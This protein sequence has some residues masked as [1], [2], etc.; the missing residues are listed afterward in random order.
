MKFALFG[1]NTENL[2]IDNLNLLIRRLL[3][4]ENVEL[5][6]YKPF[7]ESIKEKSQETQE[8]KFEKDCFVCFSACRLSSEKGLVR[9]IDA[10]AKT[11]K[12]HNDLRWYIAG[13]GPE[14]ENIKDAIRKN[15]LDDRVILLGN[16]SNP[17]PYFK[18]SN[19]V[20]NVSYHEAAP[21]VFFESKALGVPVFATET[22]S[23]R[24]IISGS[25]PIDL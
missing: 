1:R 12:K 13:D 14:R 18:N 15:H 9:A 20:I 2:N 16:Q 6:C 5:C 7:Y 10:M 3:K 21:M 11:F 24:E 19:L 22:S 23:A 4:S 25:M 8:K 17:Y